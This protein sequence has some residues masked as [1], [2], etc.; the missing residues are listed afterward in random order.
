MEIERPRVGLAVILMKDDKVL[1]GKRKNAHGA[2]TWSFPGGHIELFE[3]LYECAYRELREETGLTLEDYNLVDYHT[4]AA[5]NDFFRKENKH[6]ITLFLRAEYKSG[7]IKVMEPDKCEEWKWF[8]WK[9]FPDE[10]F[11][12]VRNLIKQGYNPFK[13]IVH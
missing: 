6:Y 10:L 8:Q 12:P 1:L 2:G 9:K 3:E 11:L 5:T 4:S 7:E 13:G